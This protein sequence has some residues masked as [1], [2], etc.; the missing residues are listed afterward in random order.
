MVKKPTI[1]IDVLSKAATMRRS[2]LYSWMMANHDTFKA[3]VDEAVRPNWAALAQA[4]AAQGLTDADNK[5]PS[6]EGTRQTWWK[7]RK[8]IA[9]RRATAAKRRAATPTRPQGRPV[10]SPAPAPRKTDAS[11]DLERL[12]PKKR[13]FPETV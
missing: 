11:S 12:F 5:P 13:G 4:F 3:V 2:P 7:V 8:A 10:E 1:P 9:A 6:S